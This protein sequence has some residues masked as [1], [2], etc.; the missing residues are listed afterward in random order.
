MISELA[1]IHPSAKIGDNVSVGPW[2]TIG[3]QVEI[4]DNTKIASHVVI[5]KN[6]R[7][8]KNNHIFSHAVLGTDPQHLAY[9]G[10]ETWLEIGDNNFIRE[11]VTINRGTK[12]VGTTKLG[13]HIYLMSYTHIAHDC[14]LGDH[15]IF[16]NNASIAGHV[17]IKDHAILGAFT[18]IHQFVTIGEYTF[19]GRATKIYQ[20][21]LPCMLVTGNPGVPK[22]INVVGLRRHN[23]NDSSL[24]N[25]KKAFSIIY[26]KSL[27]R[28]SII[29]ELEQIAKADPQVKKILDGF[30]SSKR[31]VA[32]NGGD[33]NEDTSC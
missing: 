27:N 11:F 26:R 8:G 5:E 10:E 28:D 13:N 20:D 14:C 3:E 9:Q 19:M 21:I 2:T 12:E 18:G 25:L 7:I 32:R 33:R 15:I 22:G 6:T 24:K 29:A 30:T 1:L 16:A 17:T 31:G 23:F 4:G